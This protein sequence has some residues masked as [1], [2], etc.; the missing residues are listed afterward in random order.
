MEIEMFVHGAICIAHSGRCYMSNYFRQRDANQGA[1][2][3]ACR[4]SYRVFVT[5]PRQ[6]DELMEVTE[7]EEGTFLMNSKD[8]RA[9][10]F[11]EDMVKAGIDSLKV[12]GRTKSEYYVGMVSRTYRKAIDD[13]GRGEAFDKNLLGELDKVSS[14][15]YFSGFLSRGLEARV[16]KEELEFQNLEEGR[17]GRGQTRKFSGLVTAYDPETGMATVNVRHKM[18]VGD[19]I[20][21]FV[22]G[23]FE[24]RIFRITEIFQRKK[25]MDVVSGGIGDVQIRVPLE[26]PVN[27][28][29]TVMAADPV[30]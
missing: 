26:I 18:A 20:E 5:N 17:S 1:C 21:A 28:F 14:R 22:P 2:N 16:P 15:R 19:E 24:S 12:E 6:N 23:Q 11:V 3:N 25:P 30:A 4:D 9:I 7:S 10:E 8:L 27:S 13:M 29:F